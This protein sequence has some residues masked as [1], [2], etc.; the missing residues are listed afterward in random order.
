MEQKMN[1]FESLAQKAYARFGELAKRYYYK[2]KRPVVTDGG[3]PCMLF[4]GNHSSGKSSMVN[5]LLGG[6]VQDVG[7]APTDDGFTVIV[8]GETE[9]DVCGPAAIARLPKEFDGLKLFGADFLQRLRVKVRNREL[10][11]S[12]TLIDSPGMIDSA[13]GTVNRSYDFEGVVRHLAELCDMV[14]FLLDPDKPGTTGESVTVFSR[15]LSGVEFK[16]RVLLNK[17]DAF[18]SLYD[19][20]RTY[21]TVCWNLAR[22]L[23]TKD[24]P[25]IWTV[26]SGEQRE[27]TGGIDLS[28]FNRHREEFLAV[29][30]DAPA[31]RR[32]NVFSQSLSDFL[33]LSI[34][35]CVVNHA[36]R[37]LCAFHLATFALSTILSI[38]AGAF[39][40][41]AL[42]SRS[43]VLA[44]I[45]GIVVACLGLTLGWF[46]VRLVVYLQRHR[47]A[48]AVDATFA[49]EYR[50]SIAVGTN[51]N[52]RQA[53]NAI[54]DETAQVIRSAPLRLPFFGE[55][56]RRKLDAA[57]AKVFNSF[58]SAVP[59][60]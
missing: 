3:T 7:L 29:V 31:R 60:A 1:D 26:Y 2:F 41:Q 9:E 22:V 14:F 33:G 51:D 48:D 21:G 53:W 49:D 45:A 42:L 20:A 12:V 37:R 44:I 59:G 54:R 8:Y 27:A 58:Q 19:F 17:C 4:L 32:D 56:H 15:C 18:S 35:M 11:R 28:D 36:S 39:M 43:S 38:A 5:W 52:L 40:W 13:A 34:R 30:H 10:L 57:A 55:F 24:L 46:L 25:K 23:H 50:S 47:L 16:L 6:G